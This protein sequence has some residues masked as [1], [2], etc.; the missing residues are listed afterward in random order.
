MPYRFDDHYQS[1]ATVS[2]SPISSSALA[3]DPIIWHNFNSEADITWILL[4]GRIGFRK[5]DLVLKG[6]GSTPVILAP[7]A[8][9]IEWSRYEA[10]EIRMLAEGGKEIKIRIGDQVYTQKIGPLRQYNDYRFDVHID[11]AGS[12]PFAVMPT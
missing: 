8:P 11:E 2:A 7:K 4:R 10:V 5:G 12:R 9:L 1:S 3:A 6:E